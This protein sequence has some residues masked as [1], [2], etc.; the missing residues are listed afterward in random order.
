MEKTA[1][2]RH[3]Y[4]AGEVYA[5]TGASRRHNRIAGNVY[6]R[7][8]DAA[9]GGPCRVYMETVKLRKDIF[10]YPE[11]MVACGSE[12][13]NPYYED[14]PCLVVEVVSPSTESTD[15]REKLAAYK[16]VPGLK[17]YL[18]LEQER[19]RVERHFRDEEGAW[20]R[21]DLVEEGRFSVPCP[22]MSLALAEIY[23]G[24]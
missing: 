14:A 5:M 3:E 24:L 12:P 19:M 4:V 15:R 17:A 16:R 18:I 10:Y 22:E 1:T 6:R 8:A 20:L 7:L 9:A 23:E 13:E 21:A 11:V 2:V